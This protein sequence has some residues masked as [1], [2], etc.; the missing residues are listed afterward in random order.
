MSRNNFACPR[1]CPG[2]GDFWCRFRLVL[3]VL[4]PVRVNSHTA[5]IAVEFRDPSTLTGAVQAMGGTWLGPGT[6]PLFSGPVAGHGFQLPGWRYPLVLEA[7]GELA[8][9]D[10]N[11]HWGNVADLETLKGQ[12]AMGAAE[13]AAQAQGWLCER[14]PQGL[15]IHH[16]SGGTMTV[17]ATGQVDAVG[18]VGQGCHDAILT[19]GLPLTDVQA[20]PEYGAVQAAVQLPEG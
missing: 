13:Q 3:D 16:P 18:F 12:Y 15:T 10:F 20:K 4:G 11:G 5:R 14:S 17:S 8:Y 1:T 19:L 7:S 6:H 9:D 2:A